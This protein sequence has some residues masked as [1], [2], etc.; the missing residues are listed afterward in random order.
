MVLDC[1]SVT[2]NFMLN[3]ILVCLFHWPVSCLEG[4]LG[5]I[6]LCFPCER[7]GHLWYAPTNDCAILQGWMFPEEA[8]YI[9][10]FSNMLSYHLYIHTIANIY[11]SYIICKYSLYSIW[12]VF[13]TILIFYSLTQEINSVDFG[14]PKEMKAFTN[15]RK[16]QPHATTICF[17]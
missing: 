7:W 11:R 4:Q 10:Q 3:N 17:G 6:R 16:T 2:V 14:K 5:S 9:A 1:I 12:H 13:Y 15:A 8:K